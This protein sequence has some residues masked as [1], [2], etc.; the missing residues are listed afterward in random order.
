MNT[1][2]FNSIKRIINPKIIGLII[3]AFASGLF[4]SCNDD[5]DGA[6]KT[7]PATQSKEERDDDKHEGMD[8]NAPGM[9][10]MH[11][12]KKDKN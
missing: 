11:R 3:I 12:K 4:V 5:K 9:D 1:S 6:K 10:T 7:D 2:F 8:H